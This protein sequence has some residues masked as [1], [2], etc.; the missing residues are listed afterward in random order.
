M[1]NLDLDLTLEEFER[2]FRE[3]MNLINMIK[4]KKEGLS[5]LDIKKG[6]TIMILDETFL[7]LD[8]YKYKSGKEEWVEFKIQSV[9]ETERRFVTLTD[10]DEPVLSIS[11]ATLKLSDLGENYDFVDNITSSSYLS[12]GGNEFEYDCEYPITLIRDGKRRET[13]YIYEFYFEEK[14]LVLEVWE[15]GTVEVHLTAPLANFEIEVFS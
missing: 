15:D 7:V 9:K 1:K 12:Y 8:E 4:P 2:T 6:S 11:L 14:S 13:A 10:D 3:K 5:L